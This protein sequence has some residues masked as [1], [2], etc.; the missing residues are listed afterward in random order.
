MKLNQRGADLIKQ[1]EGLKLKAYQCSAKKWTIGFGNTF[2]EDGSPV[3]QG[4]T[5]TRERADTLFNLIAD[6]FSSKVRPL[7]K[8]NLNENQYSALVSFAYNA[9][10]G[11]LQK[12]TLLRK[13]NA[14]PNDPTIRAEFMRWNRAGGQVLNGLTRRREAEANLYFSTF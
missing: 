10:I 1:F 9:G 2:Y 5:I 11:N 3:K 14:N 13:V 4:D 8:V 6:D 7:V 12:S